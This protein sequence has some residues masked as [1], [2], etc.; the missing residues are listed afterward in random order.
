MGEHFAAGY[1]LHYHIEITV[2]LW[3]NERSYF[4]TQNQTQPGDCQQGQ[5]DDEPDERLNADLKRVLQSHQKGKA[6]CLQD[7]FLVQRV[8]YLLQLHHLR[9]IGAERDVIITQTGRG[10]QQALHDILKRSLS[11]KHCNQALER[12]PSNPMQHFIYV[13]YEQ[14]KIIFTMFRR[15]SKELQNMFSHTFPQSCSP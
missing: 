12:K 2:V 6:D 3:R 9:G 10:E 5:Q 14:N 13:R 8:F 7:A 1:I 11:L 15:S 4:D